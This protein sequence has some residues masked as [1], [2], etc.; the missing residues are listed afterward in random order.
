MATADRAQ[1]PSRWSG[2]LSYT[3]SRDSALVGRASPK[4]SVGERVQ[5]RPNRGVK[6][7]VG[8]DGSG[9]ATY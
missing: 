9:D 2:S 1:A 5:P 6:E 8:H 4:Q 3:G 7:K